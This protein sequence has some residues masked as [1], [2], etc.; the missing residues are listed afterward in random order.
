MKKPV[1]VI[2]AAGMGSRYGG[3]KQIDPV[4]PEGHII[5]DFSL[6]DAKKAGFEE[7]IFIIKKENEKDFKETIGNRISKI[8]KVSYVFQELTNLP[9]GYRVPEGR[10]KPWG[11]GH[12]V[13]SCLGTLDAPFAVINADDYY[14]SHAFQMIYDF[15]TTH[16][17][18]EKYHYLM[19]GYILENTLTENG[20][21]A[22]GVCET[23]ADGYLMGIQERTHIEKRPDGTTA[24]TEDDGATWTVIPEGSTVSMN[25]W[26]FSASLLKELKERF[27]A[28]LDEAMKT[29]PLKGEYF[30]PSV[31][32]ELLA[33]DKAD[34]KVLKSL[35]KWY[36]VT[37]KEDKPVV[38]NAICKL[39]AEG[40]YPEKLWEGDIT[41]SG[42]VVVAL[43]KEELLDV[44][45]KFELGNHIEVVSVEPYGSGHINDTFRLEVKE[46]GKEKLYILQRMNK[47]IFKNQKELMDNIL[48]VTS[49]LTEKI[50]EQGGD[51]NRETLQVIP[52]KEGKA[53]LTEENGDGWRVYPF[54]TDSLSFDKADTPEAMKKSGYAFGNF[55]YL[56]SDFPAEKL[57]ETIPDFHNTVD[58]YARFEQAVQKDVMGRVKEVEAEISFIKER[59]KDCHYFG[60][61]LAA[62]EIP[63]R[64]THNDTKL[65]NVLFDKA[66]GNAICVIDLDT[67]MPGFAAHDFGDAIRFGASTAAE[68]EKDLNKVSCDMTLFEAYFNGFMEG[69]R[70]SLTDKEVEALPMGAKIMTFECGMRFLTDY[71]Q[72][73]TYFKIH[74]PE[75][76]LDR[77]R[78]QLKLVKDME[79]KWDI[80]AR[81]V[82][83]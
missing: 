69:C 74:Y 6:Y 10:V 72:G 23:D 68:D 59:E 55:Q 76:N 62:G 67:V 11:T 66:S 51:P 75:Q 78:T 26:G 43:P 37:Y 32:S 48:Q 29:N 49:F 13:L 14:G 45:G 39:K 16:E 18:D 5:M 38:V 52:T 53:Y 17:D 24:Y 7:V 33:E 22:R 61:L 2:M 70:G 15:L 60:D 28:F 35:D 82:R 65:N 36:G 57:H 77:T 8:M 83:N 63:L 54:I 79:E 1:L 31:V 34:V 58:R 25:M 9:E 30:L 44:T 40:K 42:S 12:A 20:H 50:K 81:I 27:P 47:D 3:L 41:R 21:V 46:D 80:M 73:D 19:V 64:V 4:D 56:L 71:L